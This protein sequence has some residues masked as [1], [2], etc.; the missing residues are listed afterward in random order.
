VK[1]NRKKNI[2][3]Q[4]DLLGMCT[5][6]DAEARAEETV[7]TASSPFTHCHQWLLCKTEEID[8]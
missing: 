3:T 5:V 2:S 8:P 4:A 6:H 1:I 7:R